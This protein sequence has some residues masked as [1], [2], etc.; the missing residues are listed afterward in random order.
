MIGRREF[1]TGVKAQRFVWAVVEFQNYM[2]AALGQ[3]QRRTRVS[4]ALLYNRHVYPAKPFGI[5]ACQEAQ[6]AR[7]AFDMGR[8]AV[9][10]YDR[11]FVQQLVHAAAANDQR[12]L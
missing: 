6:I 4:S 8:V 1:D 7:G 10:D 2:T 3:I 9:G 5:E 11:G 12:L